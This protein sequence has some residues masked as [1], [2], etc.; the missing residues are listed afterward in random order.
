MKRIICERRSYRD[1]SKKHSHSFGQLILPMEGR[2]ELETDRNNFVVDENHVLLVPKNCDHTY[3]AKGRNEFLVLDI[4]ATSDNIFTGVELNYEYFQYLDKRWKAIR[5]LLLE[6]RKRN[7][8]GA[9]MDLVGYAC[10]F[11]EKKKMD[12]SI[13]YIHKNYSCKI[14]VQDLADMENF[15]VS[16]FIEWFTKRNGMTP[17]MYI[18]KFRLEKAKKLLIE[19]DFNILMISQMVGYDQQ[20]SL[21]RLFRNYENSSPSEFRKINKINR[22]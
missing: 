20:S 17:N 14:S 11:L 4:P 9:L 1:K 18:Q 6:E 21:T 13:E 22:G 19:S 2:L 3:Q 8:N 16:Y 12:P 7:N 5:Y 15:N 10:S